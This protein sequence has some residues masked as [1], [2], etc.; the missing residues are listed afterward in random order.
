MPNT[1]RKKGLQGLE[2]LWENGIMTTPQSL[3][4]AI[5]SLRS[6]FN[7]PAIPALFSNISR[8]RVRLL[9]NALE[10]YIGTNLPRAI[11]A[12][13]TLQDYRTS[14][15]VLMAIGSA[16][17]LENIDDFARFIVNTKL[18]MGMETSYGKSIEKIVMEIYP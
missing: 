6:V 13:S 10:A 15:Y 17:Q 12:K 3:S 1:R 2:P 5:K 7:A 8:E 9:S 16:M 18:Y 11:D 14:P 4:E